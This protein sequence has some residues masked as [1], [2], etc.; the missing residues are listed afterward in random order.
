[1]LEIWTGNLIGAMHNA[2]IT[3]KDIAD[4]LGVS[5]AYVTMILNGARNPPKARE[6]LEAAFETVKERK[7]N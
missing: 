1:M 3:R 2:K 7:E 6:R 5:K 4:E